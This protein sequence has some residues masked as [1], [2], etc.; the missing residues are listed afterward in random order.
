M[1]LLASGT[2][3]EHKQ[4]VFI[5]LKID[6]KREDNNYHQE[7][8]FVCA[9]QPEVFEHKVDMK[10]QPTAGKDADNQRQK[11]NSSSLSDENRLLSAE[12]LAATPT[13]R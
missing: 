2:V 7:D 5:N 3:P 6:I 8:M 12:S 4:I 13:C 1:T 9:N 10:R 11:Q